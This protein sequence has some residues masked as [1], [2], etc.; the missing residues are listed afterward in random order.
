[1]LGKTEGDR[2]RGHQRMRWLD[3]ITSAMDMSLSKLR[4]IV[5]GR[6][7]GVLQFVGM[8]SGTRLNN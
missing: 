8:Q 2:K 3:S 4:E 1:M 6:K 5:K 7:P